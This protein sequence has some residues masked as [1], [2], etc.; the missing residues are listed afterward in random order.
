[1]IRVLSLVTI[2]VLGIGSATAQEPKAD[3]KLFR[4]TSDGRWISTVDSKVGNPKT[5]ITLQA[6]KPIDRNLTI[7]GLNV[8]DA[9]DQL[10]GGK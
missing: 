9:I 3:C 1:M 5:F 2:V 10:C 7:V 6:G 8:S 4:K